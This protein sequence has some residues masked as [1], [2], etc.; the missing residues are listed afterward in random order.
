MARPKSVILSRDEKKQL[1]TE[2]KAKIKAEKEIAKQHAAG[3]RTANR[4]LAAASKEHGAAM[5]T[6]DRAV[7]VSNKT[8]LSL[9]AQL[10]VLTA[11][12]SAE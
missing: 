3:I 12:T 8:L 10:A 2:L 1:V 11:P 9:E 5:K 4:H 6:I 7:A